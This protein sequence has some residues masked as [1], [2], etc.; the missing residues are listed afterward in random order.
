M[1]HGV[2]S[3]LPV[4]DISVLLRVCAVGSAGMVP[5]LTNQGTKSL[6]PLSKKQDSNWYSGS[7]PW[8]C[9]LLP[10]DERLLVFLLPFGIS[11]KV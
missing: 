11:L 5:C 10:L 1:L 9:L 2:L 8:T 7:S 6:V 4:T 3:P